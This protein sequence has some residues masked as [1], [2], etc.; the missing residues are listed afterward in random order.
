MN[1]QF[2][3][4]LQE[5]NIIYKKDKNGN[6]TDKI[7]YI[8]LDL[9]L[10]KIANKDPH[11]NNQEFKR[12]FILQLKCIINIEIMLK[13]MTNLISFYLTNQNSSIFKSKFL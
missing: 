10:L 11:F 5:T 13:K 1:F 9:L 4:E 8:S 7:Q 2:E 6:N 12:H 3:E